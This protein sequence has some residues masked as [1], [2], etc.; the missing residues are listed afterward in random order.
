MSLSTLTSRSQI[1]VPNISLAQEKATYYQLYRALLEFVGFLGEIGGRS[2]VGLFLQQ[3]HSQA[4]LME[5]QFRAGVHFCTRSKHSSSLAFDEDTSVVH[6][7]RLLYGLA[8]GCSGRA[9]QRLMILWTNEMFLLLEIS[10]PGIHH[11]STCAE[12]FSS[13][14]CSYSAVTPRTMTAPNA[15]QTAECTL[16]N[17]GNACG[18]AVEVSLKKCQP[19]RTGLFK[20]LKQHGCWCWKKHFDMTSAVCLSYPSNCCMCQYCRKQNLERMTTSLKSC[21]YLPPN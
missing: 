7:A 15:D 18:C 11:S 13:L 5:Y 16:W 14:E 2:S 10:L 9:N 12:P 6:K 20:T 8:Y 3:T 21:R 17:V 1:I 4:K 19:K